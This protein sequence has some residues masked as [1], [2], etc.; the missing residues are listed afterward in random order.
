MRDIVARLYTTLRDN[1]DLSM[2]VA[3]AHEQGFDDDEESVLERIRPTMTTIWRFVADEAEAGGWREADM[4]VVVGNVMGMITSAAVFKDYFFVHHPGAD[5][6]TVIDELTDLIVNGLMR[7]HDPPAQARIDHRPGR[8]LITG[9]DP[10][11]VAAGFADWTAR[12]GVGVRIGDVSWRHTPA[13]EPQM[14]IYLDVAGDDEP[15]DQEEST[16]VR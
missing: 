10:V 5:D 13:G 11:V 9:P 1:R 15:D 7:R 16:D 2:A 14:R 8:I 3:I 6:D 12:C 4:A